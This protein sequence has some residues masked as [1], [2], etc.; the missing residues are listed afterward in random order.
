[1]AEDK[2][3]A[4]SKHRTSFNGFKLAV[5]SAPHAWWQKLHSHVPSIA[6]AGTEST[7]LHGL[8]SHDTASLVG[9]EIVVKALKVAEDEVRA[10]NLAPG[11]APLNVQVFSPKRLIQ[12]I[13]WNGIY[14]VDKAA[15]LL[16]EVTNWIHV[17]SRPSIFPL[18][19]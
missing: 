3:E 19:C 17:S 18:I 11:D 4:A 9:K 8:G 12:S 2:I 1:M 13:W 14:G 16:C 15:R 7:S 6:G 10:T 5:R